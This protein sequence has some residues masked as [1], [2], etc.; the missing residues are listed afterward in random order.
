MES[1]LCEKPERHAP[2]RL[3]DYLR[4]EG[5]KQK[6]HSLVDK[7]YSR[8]NLMLAWERVRANQGAGGTDGIS[9][10]V[11]EANLEDNLER[12]HRELRDGTYQPQPVRRIEI[13]KRGSPGKTRPLGIP[14]VYDRVCQQAM[15]NRLEPI[16]EEVFDPSSFGYRKGRK[17]ADALSKIWREVEAGNEWIV[18]AD[19]KDYFG[20]VDHEKLMALIGKQ[21]ADGRVLKLIQH[22]LTA[23]YQEEGRRHE[24]PR[25]TPQGGV[26]SPLLS[27]ILLTPFDKEMRRQGYQ[28]TRWADDWVVTCRTRAEAEHAL[29][30]AEKILEQLGVTLNRE[31]TRIVHVAHGFEFLGFKIKRGQRQFKLSRDRIKSNLNRQNLYAVPAQKAVDRFKDQIRALTKRRVPLRMGELINT[32]NPIIRGWGNY[33]CR[34]HVRK[35]FHQLD[36]W[37]VRRLWSHRAKRWRNS[38]W[39]HYPT[40][41]LRGEEFKLV[42]LVSLIPS[43]QTA[44]AHS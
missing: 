13:P 3:S 9:V 30:R 4:L 20:S 1:S 10:E 22:T 28:L 37:I 7:V 44:K 41:R 5:Q 6:V 42:C 12:L 19:L 38:G 36:G 16:F 15:V 17:T 23:G 21:V 34:S 11:F 39:K 29:A 24:T 33:F 18:D 26:V 2:R 25:G 40:K 27:N 8:K 43:L 31:K 14:S 32:I 35:L